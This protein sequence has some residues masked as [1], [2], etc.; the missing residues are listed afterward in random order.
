MTLKKITKENITEDIQPEKILENFEKFKSCINKI[1]NPENKKAA[2][3]L[4]ETLGERLATA[5]ASSNVKYHNCFAGGLVEHTLRVLNYATILRKNLNINNDYISNDSLII[6]CLFHDLGKVGDLNNDYYLQQD[7][8]WRLNN[9]G[10][11]Y[12]INYDMKYMTVTHRSI[13]LCQQFGIKL[14]QDEMLGILLSDGQYVKENEVYKQREPILAT[15]IHHADL[16]ACKKES[17][18]F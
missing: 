8:N 17:K 15:I 2:L 11:K 3:N 18:E 5:P 7:N 10:E 6:C 1:S 4:V 14:T 12:K 9:L 13:W 16:L